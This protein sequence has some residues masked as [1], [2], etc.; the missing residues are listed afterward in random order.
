MGVA[1]DSLIAWVLPALAAT[2]APILRF[3]Y[4]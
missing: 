4:R 3:T 1:D 2:T